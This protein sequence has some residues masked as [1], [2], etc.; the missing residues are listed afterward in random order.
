MLYIGRVEYLDYSDCAPMR[1]Y[2]GANRHLDVQLRDH[3]NIW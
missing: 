2:T 3:N 1:Y